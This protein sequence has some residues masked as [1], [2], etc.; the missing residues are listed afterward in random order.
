MAVSL[1]NGTLYFPLKLSQR[2][3]HFYFSK[4]TLVAISI[5]PRWLAPRQAALRCQL[6]LA[7][8]LPSQPRPLRFRPPSQQHLRQRL[9]RER[10]LHQRGEPRLPRFE[11]QPAP[12]LTHPTRPTYRPFGAVLARQPQGS[13]RRDP[14]SACS[15]SWARPYQDVHRAAVLLSSRFP[16]PF[17]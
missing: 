15:D 7:S 9:R 2:R 14:P 11:L 4:Y 13:Q 16:V 5:T 10:P 6:R 12:H 8:Q 1:Q 3:G 17:C